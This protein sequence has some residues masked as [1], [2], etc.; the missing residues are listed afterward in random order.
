MHSCV[1][2][3]RMCLDE[4]VCERSFLSNVLQVCV[5]HI[6]RIK[7]CR[8]IGPSTATLHQSL[9]FPDKTPVFSQTLFVNTSMHPCHKQ[10]E[11]RK[12]NTTA[13]YSVAALALLPVFHSGQRYYCSKK[14]MSCDTE[15]TSGSHPVGHRVVQGQ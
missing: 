3:G 15:S 11:Y 6:Q 7:V 2:S 1:C 10:N 13:G 12:E 14:K 4:H 5:C 9:C 8:I